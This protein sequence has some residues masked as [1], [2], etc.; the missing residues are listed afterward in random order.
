MPPVRESRSSGPPPRRRPVGPHGSRRFARLSAQ[1]CS[2]SQRES[3]FVGALT[4]PAALLHASALLTVQQLATAPGWSTDRVASALRDAEQHPDVTDPVALQRVAPGTF[5][6]HRQARPAH[7]G[8]AR[9]PQPPPVEPPRSASPLR[10]C[11]ARVRVPPCGD[12]ERAAGLSHPQSRRT[13]RQACRGIEEGTGSQTSTRA[14]RSAGVRDPTPPGGR[15]PRARASAPFEVPRVA[16]LCAAAG[17]G[18]VSGR[19]RAALAR[20]GPHSASCGSGEP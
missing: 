1:P 11:R 3:S 17:L 6:H 4:V 16:P 19:P 20:T 18:Q 13:W 14:H 9:G 12:A 5:Y 8:A 10:Y 15:E 7:R 2:A